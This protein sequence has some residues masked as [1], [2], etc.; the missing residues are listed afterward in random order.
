MDMINPNDFPKLDKNNDIDIL[1]N[2]LNSKHVYESISKK[3]ESNE[4]SNKSKLYI[5][6]FSAKRILSTFPF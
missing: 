3:Y 1:Y 2:I 5:Y 6:Q 4:I